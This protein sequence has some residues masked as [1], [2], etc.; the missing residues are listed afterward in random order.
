[1]QRTQ[2]RTIKRVYGA[3]ISARAAI[4]DI[5][6][7]E[8]MTA[9]YSAE[10]SPEQ[11]QALNNLYNL[12]RMLPGYDVLIDITEQIIKENKGVKFNVSKINTM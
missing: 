5:Q 7:D 1:M 9:K 4:E 10:S 6:A 11:Q 8:R 2:Y 12:N 3:L